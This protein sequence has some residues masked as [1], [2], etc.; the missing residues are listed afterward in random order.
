V[1]GLKY[2]HFA[3][4]VPGV[5]TAWQTAMGQ[6]NFAQANLVLTQVGY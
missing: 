6:R 2:H 5:F 3:G 1:R 4:H